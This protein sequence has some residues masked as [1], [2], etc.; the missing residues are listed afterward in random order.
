MFL[1]PQLL[2]DLKGEVILPVPGHKTAPQTQKQEVKYLENFPN[3]RFLLL[4]RRMENIVILAKRGGHEPWFST[5][6]N[7]DHAIQNSHASQAWKPNSCVSHQWGGR[8]FCVVGYTSC[9]Y[10]AP[11]LSG[12]LCASA[13]FELLMASSSGTLFSPGHSDPCVL[14]VTL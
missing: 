11:P 6:P 5:C 8:C 12:P 7:L 14:M 4:S 9:L 13:C 1:T 3:W 2:Y 10:L